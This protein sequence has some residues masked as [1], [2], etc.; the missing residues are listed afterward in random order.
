MSITDGWVLRDALVDAT[1]MGDVA[2]FQTAWNTE[3]RNNMLASGPGLSQSLQAIIDAMESLWVEPAKAIAELLTVELI[4]LDV[5]PLKLMGQRGLTPVEALVHICD[6]YTPPLSVVQANIPTILKLS[7][8]SGTPLMEKIGV[9][10][11]ALYD[12]KIPDTPNL[13]FADIP[14]T[15]G[16]GH[17]LTWE[18]CCDVWQSM[19]Y[20][21]LDDSVKFDQV[22]Q[23]LKYRG[24]RTIAE[25]MIN[26]GETHFV[27][28]K[29]AKRL[30][31]VD[32]VC[33][34]VIAYIPTNTQA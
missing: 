25:R 23:P 9:L 19:P 24:L 5:C 2:A 20:W 21:L 34:D 31:D 8:S 13:A 18:T 6:T 22:V 33:L 14:E 1:H 32:I 28:L 27:N 7:S 29:R 3:N 12:A 17:N 10:Y 15:V 30:C 16:D 4:A 26:E 11:P